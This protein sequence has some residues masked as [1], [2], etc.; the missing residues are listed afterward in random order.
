MVCTDKWKLS[1]I[2]KS[3]LMGSED[4]LLRPSYV[5]A[6]KNHRSVFTSM[7]KQLI[8]AKYEHFV[9]GTEQQYYLERKLVD[10][11]QVCNSLFF[12]HQRLWL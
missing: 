7:S 4:M 11:M 2:T 10:C 1:I 6:R 8:E 3:F 12:S 5:E 9:K